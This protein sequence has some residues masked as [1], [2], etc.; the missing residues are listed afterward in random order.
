[1]KNKIKCI[2]CKKRYVDKESICINAVVV[3]VFILSL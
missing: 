1:M 2:E 3:I